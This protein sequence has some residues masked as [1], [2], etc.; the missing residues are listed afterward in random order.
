MLSCMASVENTLRLAVLHRA[1]AYIVFMHEMS[2]TG[3]VRGFQQ[4][5]LTLDQSLFTL[6]ASNKTVKQT[7]SNIMRVSRRHPHCNSGP[8][9]KTQNIILLL[10]KQHDSEK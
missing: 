1:V 6:M 3:R 8:I 2:H 5:R 9:F 10:L 4:L 7:V